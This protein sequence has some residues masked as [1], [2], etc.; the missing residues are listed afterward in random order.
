MYGHHWA[1]SHG[2]TLLAAQLPTNRTECWPIS[3]A[4]RSFPQDQDPKSLPPHSI[5]AH[6]KYH[7]YTAARQGKR[8]STHASRGFCAVAHTCTHGLCWPECGVPP[9]ELLGDG[10]SRSP[11]AHLS[12]GR[13][14]PK[15]A[16]TFRSRTRQRAGA[17]GWWWEREGRA[18]GQR[19]Y[20]LHYP[21]AKST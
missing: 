20:M 15:A 21:P 2:P 18:D 8:D 1:Y 13:S 16:E 4:A 19:T 7:Y 9:A 14:N 12:C 6:L 3:T 17:E 11:D 10:R 5:A